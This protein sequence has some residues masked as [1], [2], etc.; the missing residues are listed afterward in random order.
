MKSLLL[1]MRQLRKL[2]IEHEIGDYKGSHC[3]SECKEAAGDGQ[4]EDE[5]LFQADENA[6]VVKPYR[7]NISLK[8]RKT[9]STS[10]TREETG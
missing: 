2:T 4:E 5:L 7:R 8:I 10:S 6:P 9:C 3:V 1:Q